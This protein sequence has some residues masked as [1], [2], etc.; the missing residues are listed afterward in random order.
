MKALSYVLWF[1]GWAGSAMLA[2]CGILALFMIDHNDVSG[3]FAALS[4]MAPFPCFFIGLRSKRWST[5][6]LWLAFLGFL[7]V[8]LNDF[9]RHPADAWQNPGI[10]IPLSYFLAAVGILCT[11]AKENPPIHSE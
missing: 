2:G 3:W 7:V 1:A 10:Q 5:S 8:W 11:P 4:L 6:I 9:R